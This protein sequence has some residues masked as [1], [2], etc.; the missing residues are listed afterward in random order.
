MYALWGRGAFKTSLLWNNRVPRLVGLHEKTTKENKP[1]C[2][3]NFVWSKRTCHANGCSHGHW[4]QY[5]HQKS[6]H[7]YNWIID[8]GATYHMTNNKDHMTTY[9]LKQINIQTTNG[10]V[11]PV[12]GEGS[13]KILNSMDLDSVLVVT[14]LSSNLLS[15][16]QITEALNCYVTFWT[17]ECTFQDMATHQ[18]LGYGTRRD[19]CTTSKRTIEVKL[20]IRD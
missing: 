1:R 3:G 12:T 4:L 10:S 16:S 9:S 5:V 11:A 2:N 14:S 18:T 6:T 7:N 19:G 20:I 13:V 8:T 17:N 15:V